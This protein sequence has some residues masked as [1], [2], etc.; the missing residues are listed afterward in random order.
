MANER[1]IKS[2]ILYLFFFTLLSGIF[3]PG[4]RTRREIVLEDTRISNMVF[5]HTRMPEAMRLGEEEPASFVLWS[6]DNYQSRHVLQI[7]PYAALQPRFHRRHDVTLLIVSGQAIVEVEGERN[8]VRPGM[9]VTVPRMH[10]FAII[11]HE[12]P[13]DLIAVLVYSPPFDGGDVLVLE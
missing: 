7:A 8:Y 11:P 2:R 9:T 3:L 10:K 12:S 1:K 4:C 13:G 5:D 6:K